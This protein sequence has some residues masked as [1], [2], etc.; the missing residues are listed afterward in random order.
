MRTLIIA[1]TIFL[2]CISARHLRQ[3]E[4]QKCE[5]EYD[6]KL[7]CKV[8]SRVDQWP[9]FPGGRDEM[10]IFI[11]KNILVVDDKETDGRISIGLIIDAKGNV[12]SE[13]IKNKAIADYT[14]LEK[15]VL[16][17]VRLMPK[18]KPGKC[19]NRKVAVSQYF[20]M[21]LHPPF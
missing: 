6:Q 18:W 10:H 2:G 7:K 1:V 21:I 16:R 3:E 17:V 11:A 13:H 8:Y 9:E 19:K 5:Y 15:E 12:V 14:K 4:I 20:R